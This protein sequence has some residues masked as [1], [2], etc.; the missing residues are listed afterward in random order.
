VP[1]V[2]T[3]ASGA[4]GRRLV[5]ML[6][7]GGSEVRAV[8]RSGAAADELRAHGAKVAVGRLGDTDTVEAVMDGAHTVVHLV[9]GLEI[10]K[11]AASGPDITPERLYEEANLLP[12]R[13]VLEAAAEAR[14]TRFL[15]LSYPGASPDA[16]NP[17]LRAKGL[18][19]DDI[20]A[21]GLQHAIVRSTHI[22][23]QGCRW[24]E[25]MAVSAQR[26]IAVVV[27]SGRQALA[28]VFVGDVARGL[29]AADDRAV[30]VRGTFGLQGPDV[31]TADDMID[32]LAG[33]PKRKLH[34]SPAAAR[35]AARLM[36]RIVPPAVLDVLARDSLADRPDAAAEFGVP[37]T[38]LERGLAES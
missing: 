35:R 29:A 23:G 11:A 3:G 38:K 14:V 32:L 34:L 13:W 2:V 8:I 20:R 6:V 19:E 7:Q 1:V 30:E 25:E 28:P 15:F 31:V 5:P 10:T 21:S 18:A 16:P 24:M 9:G 36:G 4:V 37:L 33:R 12:T 27:G 17:Y 22:Y 26:P